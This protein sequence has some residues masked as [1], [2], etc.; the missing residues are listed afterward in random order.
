MK[1]IATAKPA[2]LTSN[3]VLLALALQDTMEMVRNV[4]PGGL[5]RTFPEGYSAVETLLLMC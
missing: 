3:G 5:D 2:L 4:T 1:V